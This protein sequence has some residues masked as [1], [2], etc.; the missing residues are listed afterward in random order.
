MSDSAD[1]ELPNPL[2]GKRNFSFLPCPSIRF[3][4]DR[5]TADIRNH[6]SQFGSSDA[7]CVDSAESVA[8]ERLV[9]LKQKLRSSDS[10]PFW[11]QLMG[12]LTSI[13]NAQFGFVVRKVRAEE[14]P[15]EMRECW[16]CLLGMVFYYNDG[17]QHVG[18]QKNRYLIGGNPLSHMDYNKPCLIPEGLGSF[19]QTEIDQLPFAPEAYLSIP[20]FSRGKC[21]AHL[22]LMWSEE[23]LRKRNL[24]WLSLEM[25]LYSLE[26]LVVQR[27]L[28]DSNSAKADLQ[29]EGCELDSLDQ[30]AVRD[31][32]SIQSNEL[33]EGSIQPF[34]PY[35]RSLSH[36]LRTPMQGVVGMLDV[37]HATVREAIESKSA[38][39][40]SD[41]FQSLKESI[42]MVQGQ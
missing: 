28:S 13:C 41:V 9:E 29:G 14:R 23:G 40:T 15:R 10:E 35:A 31:S 34:K 39:K 21:L 42:E 20:L 19:S 32:P 25:T 37:M 8:V 36:E 24:A 6:D 26:D 27:I 18:M 2:L 4:G 12:D 3:T 38:A 22:G 33:S 7:G 16:H 11:D 17:Y 1:P 5:P 30:K